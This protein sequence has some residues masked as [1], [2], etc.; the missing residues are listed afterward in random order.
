MAETI[1]RILPQWA[2][3]GTTTQTMIFKVP[4]GTEVQHW[5]ISAIVIANTDTAQHYVSL[6]QVGDGETPTNLNKFF[7]AC[8]VK[9]SQVVEGGRGYIFMAG[10][11]LWAEADGDGVNITIYYAERTA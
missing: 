5:I 4:N 7:P 3:D 8:P 1:K 6:Y 10:D 11:E 9:A 2:A